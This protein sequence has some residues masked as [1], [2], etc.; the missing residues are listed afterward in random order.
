M[1]AETKFTVEDF[2]KRIQA[3]SD[4]QLLRDGKA[5]RCSGCVGATGVAERQSLNRMIFP[6]IITGRKRVSQTE[7][8]EM[9]PRLAKVEQRAREAQQ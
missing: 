8:Q 5:A 6:T 2:R 1:I 7:R 9:R 3:M 4:G